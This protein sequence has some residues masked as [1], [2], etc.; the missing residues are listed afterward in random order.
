MAVSNV[1]EDSINGWILDRA[2]VYHRHGIRLRHLQHITRNSCWLSLV[3][4]L[5]PC[6]LGSIQSYRTIE[7]SNPRERYLV[8]QN[9][10]IKYESR[11]YHTN[12]R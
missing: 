6:D 3:F 10:A 8:G 2:A 9:H 11:S 5:V 12:G 4:E 7:K 1:T